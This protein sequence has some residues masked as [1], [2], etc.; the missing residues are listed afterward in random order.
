[1][2]AKV[3]RAEKALARREA[4]IAAATEVFVAN[5]FAATRIEDIAMRAGVA[6]GTVYLNFADKEAL[7]EGAVKARLLPIAARLSAALQ[8]EHPSVRETLE[9]VLKTAVG[10]MADPKAAEMVRL[11]VSEQ[12]RFPAL[13]GFYRREVV[14]PIA[15]RCAQLLSRA[16]ERGELTTPA[17]A[18][19]PL[20]VIA[21]LMV[22]IVFSRT[23][24]E[25]GIDDFQS[26]LDAHLDN[27]FSGPN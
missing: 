18:K 17:T 10:L 27:I 3:T 20:L 11:V 12:I 2:T 13:T 5:G 21:P 26:M 6:K 14:V 19:Y 7:F 22:S 23:L 24:Q 1:M 15:G 9:G 4:I 25:V 16:A 8:Q